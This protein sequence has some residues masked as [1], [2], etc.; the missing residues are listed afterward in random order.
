[1]LT[2]SVE[3]VDALNTLLSTFYGELANDE[4]K[5]SGTEAWSLVC[6][7][8]WRIVGDITLHRCLARC[9][10]F[11]GGVKQQVAAGYLWA[12]LHAHRVMAENT[13]HEFRHHPSIAPIINYHTYRH[14]VP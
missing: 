1:M 7:I 8:V 9:V 5:T 11:K 2:T 13:K 12:S 4:N 10:D 3:F 14:R 6:S